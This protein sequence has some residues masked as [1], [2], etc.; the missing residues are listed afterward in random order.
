[1]TTIGDDVFRYTTGTVGTPTFQHGYWT[2]PQG[3]QP[4]GSR[5]KRDPKSASRSRRSR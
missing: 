4:S 5:P 1:M 3:D 2:A